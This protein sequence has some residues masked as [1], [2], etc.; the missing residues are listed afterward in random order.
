M[1]LRD[2]PSR[3]IDA[4]VITMYTTKYCGYCVAARRLLQRRGYAYEDID[5]SSDPA[6]RQQI[7]RR[8][9]N[10]RTVPM[11]FIGDEFIGGFDQLAAMD[12]SGALAAHS[13]VVAAGP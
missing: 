9:G 7:S 2:R 1:G 3:Y 10:Y 13:G 4:D 6:L 5:V 8:A 11:I 12:R